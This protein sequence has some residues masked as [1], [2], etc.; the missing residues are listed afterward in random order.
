M[1]YLFDVSVS[2]K[3][4]NIS[5]VE[6][7]LTNSCIKNNLLA[8]IGID[9]GGFLLICVSGS[10]DFGP[11][12]HPGEFKILPVLWVVLVFEQIFNHFI[13]DHFDVK[14]DLAQI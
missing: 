7:L 4:Y 5:I 11:G 1:C 9:V 12:L 2:K 6:V 14:W 3:D 10:V 8:S 13:S